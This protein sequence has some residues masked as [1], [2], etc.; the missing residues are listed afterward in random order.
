MKFLIAAALAALALPA[1][2]QER[3]VD[4]TDLLD[5]E[6][7]LSAAAE[8]QP[9]LIEFL[10]NDAMGSLADMKGLAAEDKA[11]MGANF[12]TYSLRITD[13]DRFDAGGYISLVRSYATYTGGAHG[14][15][16]LDPL[17][18]S[19]SARDFVRLDAFLVADIKALKA[20][21][22]I[23]AELRKTLRAKHGKDFET[24]K[25]D[26]LAATVPDVTVLQ[27]FTLEPSTNPGKVGGIAF[28]FSPYEVGPYSMSPVRVIIPQ[29]VFAN[30][31]RPEFKSLFAGSPR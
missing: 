3:I 21:E 11:D 29:L 16:H 1:F 25:D 27:N 6:V 19:N 18:W 13:D 28:H 22:A 10:R 4:K 14:N 2:A 8:S 26:V 5:A 17:T 30:A 20:L 23:S 9:A 15:E 12:R 24:W 7:T 31:L